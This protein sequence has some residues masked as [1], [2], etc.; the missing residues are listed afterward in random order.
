MNRI[1]KC[2]SHFLCV[3]SQKEEEE[4]EEEEEECI[5]CTLTIATSVKLQK[6]SDFYT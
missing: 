2:S 5:G 6:K 3:L 1:Q 4:E